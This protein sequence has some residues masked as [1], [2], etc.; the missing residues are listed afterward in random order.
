MSEG[1]AGLG[2]MAFLRGNRRVFPLHRYDTHVKHPHATP[3]ASRAES[4]LHRSG[5]NALP[6][7]ALPANARG[8]HVMVKAWNLIAKRSQLRTCVSVNLP[9]RYSRLGA[10]FPISRR[11]HVD[12]NLRCAPS[13]PPQ[14]WDLACLR[15]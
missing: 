14:A 9:G 15:G 4:E 10:G 12:A 1:P 2:P 6:A 7:N 11:G 5:A 3:V 8:S 13:H